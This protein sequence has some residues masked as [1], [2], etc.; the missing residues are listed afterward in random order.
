M[1]DKGL[2]EEEIEYLLDSKLAEDL[3]YSSG[4][5]LGS[6]C[7]EPIEFANR[8]YAKYLCKNIGDRGLFPATSALEHELI[9][10][11]GTLFH[12]DK[13]YGNITSGGSESNIIAMRIAKKLR[14]DV[15]A[16]EIVVPASAHLSFYKAGDMMGFEIKPARLKPNL[17]LD[18]DH[19]KSLITGNTIA[20][21]GVAGTTVNGLIDPIKEMGEIAEH[22]QL[23]FHVDAAFGGFVLPFL[24]EL[25]YNIP[26]W[27]FSVK[28]VHSLTADPHK[29]GLS[30][31]PS[32]GFVMRGKSHLEKLGFEITYLAGGAYKHLNILG[33]RPGAAVIAFWALMQYL[34]R[35]GYRNIVKECME[36]TA[37]LE[38][39]ISEIPAIKIPTKPV[40]N[41]VGIS[42][43]K[44]NFAKKLDDELRKKRY[45]LGL[46]KDYNLLRICLMPHVKRQHIDTFCRELENILKKFQ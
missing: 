1:R 19:F 10:E 20:I 44:P 27:D 39:R 16:P 12:C 8:I 34:G 45:M 37:Y 25:G 18:L 23:Y 4:K 36:N 6:M 41:V 30:V 35:E 5:I 43:E 32:G 15:K 42:P 46:F 24:K 31:I 2:S 13:A 28:Q 11:L 14:P 17:E 33:T 9:S 7:T 26:P 40:M 22:K 3:D 21:V 38:Q 29:M